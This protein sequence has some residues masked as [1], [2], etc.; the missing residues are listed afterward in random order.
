[1]RSMHEA[2]KLATYMHQARL[3]SAYGSP[4]AVLSTILAGRELGFNALASLRAFHIIENKHTL[5]ADGMR[6]L[7]LKSG[8]AKFFRCI[9]RPA[10]RCTWETHRVGDP[11]PMRLTYTIDQGK[12]MWTKDERAWKQS[13][14]GR[15]PEDML[16]ARASGKLARLVYSDIL[17]GLY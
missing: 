13:G 11:E 2:A 16:S 17:F 9:E 5:S 3:F 15:N 8:M 1:P 7:V 14:W 4:H 12:A 6:A 10:E